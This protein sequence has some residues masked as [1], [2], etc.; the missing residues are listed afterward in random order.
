MNPFFKFIFLIGF[1]FIF[2]LAIVLT[3]PLNYHSN[4]KYSTAFLKFSYLLY[5]AMFLIFTFI[6][7]FNSSKSVFYL[8][9]PTNTNG[10]I[11]FSLILVSFSVPNVAIMARRKV[12]RR[13]E[14]NIGFGIANIIFSGYLWFL[15]EKT[16]DS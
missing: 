3:K 15:I 11:Y 5:L 1:L 12:K 6:F 8:E 9:N 7:I 13:L 4:R 14:Y 2:F 10:I 16:L